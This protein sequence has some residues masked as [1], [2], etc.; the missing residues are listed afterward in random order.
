MKTLLLICAAALA[1][2]GPAKADSTEALLDKFKSLT[3][4]LRQNQFSRSLVLSS[5]E[6]PN[7]VAGDIH[8]VVD[9]PFNNLRTNLN[10]PQHWCEVISLHSNTKYC[11][12]MPSPAGSKLIVHI[13]AKTPEELS[14]VGRLEFDYKIS[15]ATPKYMSLLLSAKA[16][17]LGT[18]NYQIS[19]EA[20]PLPNG[21]SFLHLTY[22]YNVSVMGRL[23]M[24]TYLATA[25]RGKV[26]FTVVGQRPNGEPEYVG[27][28]RGVVERNTM[29]Y[30][31]AIDALLGSTRIPAA[32]Q[33]EHRLQSWFM[34]TER[35]PL[36]LHEMESAE[37]LTM[38]RA[39]RVREQAVAPEDSG[40]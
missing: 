7:Q 17:P 21:Q 9:Y 39:E 19:L 40:R 29:R 6:S 22:S 32:A 14:R 26:G 35:Y 33:L 1:F 34:A 24:Q 8:A 27:G 11:R 38:K 4:D 12:P 30:Y 23:A 15:V 16:G 31:L 20:I 25:G 5:T 28:V 13:G 18:S 10:S 2:T 3:S 36:Q 37:Y